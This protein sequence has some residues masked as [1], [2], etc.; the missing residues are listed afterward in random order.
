MGF[1]FTGVLNRLLHL[2]NLDPSTSRLHPLPSAPV[3]LELGGD[4][5]PPQIGG[6]ARSARVL[7]MADLRGGGEWGRDLR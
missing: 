5:S 4:I 7:G 6:S 3:R 2:P 1:P